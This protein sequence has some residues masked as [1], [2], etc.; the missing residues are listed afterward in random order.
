MN[1]LDG[2]DA[3]LN[4]SRRARIASHKPL[5]IDRGDGMAGY[6]T[7][8]WLPMARRIRMVLGFA[9][10]IA[11]SAS[12]GCTARHRSTEVPA[13]PST[14]ERH[15]QPAPS[16]WRPRT[17][18]PAAAQRA[19]AGASG[20]VLES[21]FP[22][23]RPV[24]PRWTYVVIHHS[25]TNV[26]SARSFDAHHRAKGWNELG[27][28]F[29]IGNGSGSPD[30]MIEVGSRWDKQKHGAHCKTADNY[31]N[32]HGIGICL[33]GDFTKSRPTRKQLSSL[34]R[35]TRFLSQT[36]RIPPNRVTT[37]GDLTHKTECPGDNF[38]IA[39]LRNA[40]AS[41]ATASSMK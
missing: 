18:Q 2:Q 3:R 27:Y 5:L 21:W 8:R 32:D 10:L 4:R 9:C 12:L 26:G 25:A 38:P 13:Q 39:A 11:I 6:W 36:C 19:P 29:V 7:H 28:H 33:V 30:G 23:G 24:S 1:E 34:Y 20:G 16:T 14:A 37:H 15:V 40:L 41:P 17:T 35:L 22:R 31:Y